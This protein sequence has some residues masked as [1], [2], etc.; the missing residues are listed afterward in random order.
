MLALADW[1]VVTGD[2][3]SMLA[4]ACSTSKPVSIHALPPIGRATWQR[5]IGEA[6]VARAMSCLPRAAD[7]THRLPW[8]LAGLCA[9]SIASGW[10]LP[11]RDL[12]GL[13][14]NLIASGRAHALGDKIEPMTVEPL[15]EVES[16][17]ARVRTLFE[18]G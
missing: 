17:A 11:P 2:S 4:E 7:A 16:V 3:E 8:T 10:I 12:D 9:W 5:R 18:G 13:R 15:L 6:L 1:I 14:E